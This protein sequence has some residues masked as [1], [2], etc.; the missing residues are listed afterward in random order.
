MLVGFYDIAIY[1]F[2]RYH[3]RYRNV[4]PEATV[5]DHYHGIS[6]AIKAHHAMKV[7]FFKYDQFVLGCCSEGATIAERDFAENNFLSITINM[8]VTICYNRVL[9][10]TQGK[11]GSY[12]LWR[13]DQPVHYAVLF[14]SFIIP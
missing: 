7:T 11:A 1:E 9:Y 5:A 8:I 6:V 3:G 12:L 2:R 13:C 10:D 4:L 14:A